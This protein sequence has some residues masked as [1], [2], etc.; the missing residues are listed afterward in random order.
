MPEPTEDVITGELTP[1]QI[2]EAL[3]DETDDEEETTDT[4]DTDTDTEDKDTDDEDKDEDTE[5][6]DEDEDEE[7]DEDEEEDEEE[8]TD[9]LEL[10]APVRRKEIL[11]KYPKLFKEFP[12]LEKAYYAEQKFREMF[13]TLDDAQEANEKAE[14]LDE[15][16]QHL[17]KGDTTTVLKAVKENDP[18]AFK[19]VVDAYLPTLQKI[20]EDAYYHVV[21][22]VINGTIYSLAQA[23]KTQDNKQLQAAAQVV[24]QFVFGR[25]EFVPQ[26]NLAKSGNDEGKSD[27]DREREEFA[28][29]RFET[30]RDEVSDKLEKS[31]KGVIDGSIDPKDQ[32]TVFI[33]KQ[34]VRESL[35]ALRT[36][37][38]DDA[39]FTSIIDRLWKKARESNYSPATVT[40]I[41]TTYLSK[42][43]TVLPGVIKKSRRE[44]LQGL[45][46]KV[47]SG[48]KSKS[49]KEERRS[50]DSKKPSFRDK[51]GRNMSTLDFLNT[52]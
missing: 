49:P 42:A 16:E 27:L 47:R 1:D 15:H 43:K 37:I 4:D 50:T 21:A 35:E 48:R 32:M 33:K 10:V 29:Q 39:S 31:L 44:A 9:K 7:T 5:D 26:G 40:K 41:R 18:D 30:A 12:Y 25:K 36:V 45:G 22:G 8:D 6:E 51:D 28:Q 34:A 11:A 2:L 3:S 20:D 52:D 24:N 17:M 13:G 38:E 46:T 23:G 14:T 19:K